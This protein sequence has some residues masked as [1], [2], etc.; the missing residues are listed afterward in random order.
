MSRTGARFSSEFERAFAA[1]AAER[2]DAAVVQGIFF[3]KT[4]ADL[5]I[6]H[7]SQNLIHNQ[8]S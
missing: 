7:R 3:P 1:M 5:A 2:V 8:K 4:V 6:K